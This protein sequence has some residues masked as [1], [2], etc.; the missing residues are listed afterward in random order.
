MPPTPAVHH[1]YDQPRVGVKGPIILAI[2]AVTTEASGQP[3]SLRLY[4]LLH[5]LPIQRD[6]LSAVHG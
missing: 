6:I 3:I 1:L 2:V 4:L 5:L